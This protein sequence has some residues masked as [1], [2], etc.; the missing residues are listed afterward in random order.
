[1]KMKETKGHV[2]KG[3]DIALYTWR[4]D[5]WLLGVKDGGESVVTE[6]WH[7]ETVWQLHKLHM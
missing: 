7:K 2:N 5:Q 1:M 6:N 3:R 4:T